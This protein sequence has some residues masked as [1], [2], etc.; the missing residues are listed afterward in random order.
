[1][2]SRAQT[3]TEKARIAREVE[4]RG[5]YLASTDH[6]AS[7]RK[8]R[9]SRVGSVAGLLSTLIATEAADEDLQRY[10]AAVSE[11]SAP[12]RAS[13]YE[14]LAPVAET[15]FV[16]HAPGSSRLKTT[17][18]EPRI[19]GESCGTPYRSADT[20][21]GPTSSASLL[22]EI[23]DSPAVAEHYRKHALYRLSEGLVYG[24]NPDEPM[25][26][27]ELVVR[28]LELDV[29]DNRTIHLC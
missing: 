20:R 13:A 22:E 28:Q 17:T 29:M 27:Q 23:H 4:E 1:M 5:I 24:G 16:T 8:A 7:R 2:I 9:S 19:A 15:A 18:V 21:L 10:R 14:E 11:G 3:E 6:A 25:T 26:G 12:C